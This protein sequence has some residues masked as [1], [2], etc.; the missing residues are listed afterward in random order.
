MLS[1][2]A[3]LKSS[4]VKKIS[5][6]LVEGRIRPGSSTGWRIISKCKV[7]WFK[8][9]L[10]PLGL[11]HVCTILCLKKDYPTDF[12]AKITLCFSLFSSKW[13]YLWSFTSKACSCKQRDIFICLRIWYRSQLETHYTHSW[14]L[15]FHSCKSSDS[16]LP[17]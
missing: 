15:T 17:I 1:Y 8:L 10:M 4:N 14:S 9:Y 3:D 5:C 16:S 2:C 7:K 12:T 11:R 6:Q 13:K